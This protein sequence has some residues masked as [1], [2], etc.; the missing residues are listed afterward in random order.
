M[1]TCMLPVIPI[2][3]RGCLSVANDTYMLSIIPVCYQEYLSV[4]KNTFLRT[5]KSECYKIN[6]VCCKK[7]HVCCQYQSIAMYLSVA[8][9]TSI[10]L[11]MPVCFQEYFSVVNDTYTYVADDICL[12]ARMHVCYQCL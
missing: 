6:P 11:M 9:F 4:A 7:I 8:N 2:C 3:G 12:F 5:R 1:N 10:L